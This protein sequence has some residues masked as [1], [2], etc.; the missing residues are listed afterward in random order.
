MGRQVARDK[1]RTVF[2]LDVPQLVFPEGA[3]GATLTQT[4]DVQINGAIR[5]ISVG[6]N[7]NTGNK[8]V[9]VSIID[10]DGAILIALATT[11]EN[12]TSAPVIQQFMTLSLTDLPMRL[13]CAGTITVSAVI[14]GDPGSSTGLADVSIYMD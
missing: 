12:T 4:A 14:S 11:A 1:V 3:T 6:L 13:M 10:A 2:K 7:N 9:D 8:T 5:A